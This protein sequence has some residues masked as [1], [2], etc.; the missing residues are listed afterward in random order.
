MV[1]PILT[2]ILYCIIFSLRIS[3]YYF[4]TNFSVTGYTHFFL[5]PHKHI[6]MHSYCTSSEVF[7]VWIWPSACLKPFPDHVSQ[8]LKDQATFHN[9]PKRNGW[10][11]T[12][13][14][15]KLAREDVACAPWSWK[16]SFCPSM[17]LQAPSVAPLHT[18]HWHL[19]PPPPSIFLAGTS[20]GSGL[21]QLLALLWELSLMPMGTG[22]GCLPPL[23][24][25]VAGPMLGHTF[26]PSFHS[27]SRKHTSCSQAPL[28]YLA[29]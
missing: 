1:F 14:T 20:T 11:H 8:A 24:W 23:L 16:C 4:E 28:K 25:E 21:Q 19:A 26:Q 2:F 6:F 15:H 17:H 7:S 29:A 10:L 3:L 9:L 12:P 5:Q 27:I 13:S 22:L 18:W